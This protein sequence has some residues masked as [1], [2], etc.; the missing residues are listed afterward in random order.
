MIHERGW[1]C[2]A[3]YHDELAAGVVAEYLRRAA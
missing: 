1:E 2:F 3:T